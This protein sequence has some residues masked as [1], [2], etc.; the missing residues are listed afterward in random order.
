MILGYSDFLKILNERP[1]LGK[2][3]VVDT[4]VLISATYESDAFFDSTTEFLSL[5]AENEVPIYCNVNVR[6]EFLEIHRRLIFSEALF[7]FAD[8]IDTPKLPLQLAQQLGKWSKAN[9][10]RKRQEKPPLR[11]SEADLKWVKLALIQV[12][13]GHKDLWTVLCENRIG[14]KLSFLWQKTVDELGLNFL[15]LRKGDQAEHLDR[16][17]EWE[18]AIKLIEQQGLSS[19]DAMILNM[20]LVSKF[21]ALITSDSEIAITLKRLRPEQKLCFVPDQLRPVLAKNT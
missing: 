6:A 14:D 10:T 7:D 11:L 20:F 9:E 5:I 19:S 2:G 8:T 16:A 15:T 18:D 17:P 12:S 21:E 1:A 3:L 4:N 13:D